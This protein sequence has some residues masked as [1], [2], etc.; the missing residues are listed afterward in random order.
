MHVIFGTLGSYVVAKIYQILVH[1]DPLT[2][3]STGA[4]PSS[5]GFSLII[6]ECRKNPL[7]LYICIK[8]SKRVSTLAANR[9]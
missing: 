6:V 7:F 9:Y 5:L 8:A 4:E 3:A 2:P 1:F